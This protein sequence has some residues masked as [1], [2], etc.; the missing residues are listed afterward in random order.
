MRTIAAA[1]ASTR[2]RADRL[3]RLC[4][5]LPVPRQSCP[6]PSG[7]RPAASLPC[8]ALPRPCPFPL[9]PGLLRLFLADSPGREG[10]CSRGGG[11]PES[12]PIRQDGGSG[13]GP[14]VTQ[15]GL[16]ASPRDESTRPGDAGRGAGGDAGPVRGPCVPGDALPAA[17]GPPAATVCQPPGCAL[18]A[19]RSLQ[20]R[21]L[22][23]SGLLGARLRPGRRRR[24]EGTG[25]RP[26]SKCW[27]GSAGASPAL[28]TP[29]ARSPR[30]PSRSAGRRRC[31]QS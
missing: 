13:A 22:S 17:R 24:G 16:N 19:A 2:A 25:L 26:C 12:S 27:R 31:P 11:R 20:T 29:G 15:R 10:T 18:T 14:G 1:S 28:C 23:S 5:S 30:S 9:P 7:P 8:P 21:K 6:P 3:P 4:A